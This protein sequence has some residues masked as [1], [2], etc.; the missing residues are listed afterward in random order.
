MFTNLRL[1]NPKISLKIGALLSLLAVAPLL[2]SRASAAPPKTQKA[3]PA[4]TIVE[5]A[6]NFAE[7][8]NPFKHTS[9]TVTLTALGTPRDLPKVV[10]GRGSM[11]M[12][13]DVLQ[14]KL[15]LTF[16]NA[17]KAK[18][19]KNQLLFN[20]SRANRVGLQWLVDDKPLNYASM[21]A[22]DGTATPDALTAK[23]NWNGADW[24][25]MA[26]LENKTKRPDPNR[27]P[28]GQ[29]FP[30]PSKDDST[31]KKPMVI[32]T[33]PIK[34]KPAK[35][36]VGRVFVVTGRFLVTNS[37]DG[38]GGIFG[39]ADDSVELS[40]NISIGQK[41]ALSL[42]KSS[43]NA[44]K[45]YN[46]KSFRLPLRYDDPNFHFS[47]VNGSIYDEDKASASDMLWKA[48]QA[49]DLTKIMESNR[50]F[51]IQGDRKSESGDLYIRVTDGGEIME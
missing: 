29:T 30:I 43:A 24:L 34:M 36:A 40:G 48:S 19:G 50:E 13:G 2:V 25:L 27:K 1:F 37:E 22:F 38:V 23:I 35:K 47:T 33:A 45:S 20:V 51:V 15:D 10:I 9:A 11:R 7:K 21:K 16:D 41:N 18:P 44:G 3:L 4:P 39:N 6:F 31:G 32:I 28:G 42:N 46:L 49:I 14:G 8:P 26:T 5:A 17:A 12:E